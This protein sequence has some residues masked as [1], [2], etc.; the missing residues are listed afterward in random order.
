MEN[1]NTFNNCLIDGAAT[2]SPAELTEEE[3]LRLEAKL[4]RQLEWVGVWIPDEVEIDGKKVPLH[5]V[6]W[7]LVKKKSLSKEDESLLLSLEEK[8]NQRFKNDLDKIERLDTTGT[9]ALHDYCD[10]AGLLRAIITMK[11]IESHE[12]KLVGTDEMRQRITNAKKEQAKIWL[13]FLRQIGL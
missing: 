12:E 7:E 6:I 11:E 3:R 9:Q 2:G 13:D 5:K 8:L 10:A 4:K 1:K